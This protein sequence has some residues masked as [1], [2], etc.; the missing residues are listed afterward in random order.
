M[1]RY[2]I[3]KG[4]G[5]L[6]VDLSET[7]PKPW[8]ELRPL[9]AFAFGYTRNIALRD[10]AQTP[11]QSLPS[12]LRLK[13]TRGSTWRGRAWHYRCLVRLGST[14]FEPYL[15]HYPRYSEMPE[16]W[17]TNWQERL[18]GLVAHELWHVY[19]PD[20]YGKAAE[21]A[22]ELI[23]WDAIEAFRKYKGYTFV[24]PERIGEAT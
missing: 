10:R 23:E 11:G 20:D 1:K 2:I 4:K 24:P 19:R 22:C 7:L 21:Y 18:V 15:S 17:I 14:S 16:F 3:R 13:L 5:Q 6:V 8:Q 12:P 9:V